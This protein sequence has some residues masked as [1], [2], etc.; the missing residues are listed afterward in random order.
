MK[1][2]LV[3]IV[4]VFSSF[5]SAQYNNEL[6]PLSIVTEMTKTLKKQ[7]IDTYFYVNKTCLG[8]TR[9]IKMNDGTNCFTSGNFSEYYLFWQKNDTTYISKADNCGPFIKLKLDDTTMFNFFLKH[10]DAIQNNSVKK[11]E[12]ANPENAPTQRT[13]VHPCSQEFSFTTAMG[14]FTQKFDEFDL[15]NDSKQKNLNYEYNQQLKLIELEAMID[16]IILE[17]ADSLRRQ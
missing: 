3:C 6:V 2:I 16:Q 5:C 7:N 13:K 1:S 10:K 17:T 9:I 14:T 15:T 8:E 4:L 12:V 11:Y